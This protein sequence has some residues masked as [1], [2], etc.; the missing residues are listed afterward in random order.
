MGLAESDGV[1]CA[2]AVG[3]VGTA[4]FPFHL[5]RRATHEIGHYLGLYHTWGDGGCEVDDFVLDT[6]NAWSEYGCEL[7][8]S[9][10]VEGTDAM[11][12][13]TWTILT[14]HEPVH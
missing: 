14:M 10:C 7:G 1:V 4:T 2:M 9:S 11:V 13:N 12:Q 3:N 6:P 5:G 8:S